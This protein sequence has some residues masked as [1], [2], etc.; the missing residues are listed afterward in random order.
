M[1]GERLR[2]L[3]QSQSRS[4]AEVAGKAKISV[5]TLSRIE[6]NKQSVE[7]GLFMTL[8]RVLDVG[9]KELLDDHDMQA[10]ESKDSLARHIAA[11]SGRD[12]L[13]LWRSLAEEMRTQR[14]K[15]RSGDAVQ[16]AQQVEELLAQMDVLR[17][18]L[19]AIRKHVK[20]R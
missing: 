9:A 12:R 13:D 17:E 16:L 6:N 8:A 5:A 7:I 15:R 2:E 18:E 3:R 14:T 19:E 20:K 10:N 4:L 11:L 1:V